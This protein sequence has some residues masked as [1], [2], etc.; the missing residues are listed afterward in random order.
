MQG[1]LQDCLDIWSKQVVIRIDAC[2]C[3]CFLV[4]TRFNQSPDDRHVAPH[5]Q[6]ACTADPIIEHIRFT[7]APCLRRTSTTLW[8]RLNAARHRALPHHEATACKSAPASRRYC[9]VSAEPPNAAWCSGVQFLS[10]R[11]SMLAPLLSVYA[12]RLACWH[13]PHARKRAVWI[14]SPVGFNVTFWESGG[15]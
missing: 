1:Q 2:F 6:A 3:L 8:W 14:W 9:T 13:S 7:L 10:S 15:A 4:R 11:C 5:T 12:S